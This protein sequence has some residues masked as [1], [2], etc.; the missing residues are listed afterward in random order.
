MIVLVA[1]VLGNTQ[2]IFS[3]H[4]TIVNWSEVL[5]GTASFTYKA[6]NKIGWMDRITILGGTNSFSQTGEVSISGPDKIV[7][8][9]YVPLLIK[10]VFKFVDESTP[11]L[12]IPAEDI[13]VQENSNI[14]IIVNAS[15]NDEDN[16]AFLYEHNPQYLVIDHLH[17]MRNFRKGNQTYIEDRTNEFYPMQALIKK[18]HLITGQ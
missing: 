16:L 8:L 13:T 18:L 5:E 15:V 9:H 1:E 6:E 7:T 11:L 12:E 3:K 17:E 4:N 2:G 10:S 14:V